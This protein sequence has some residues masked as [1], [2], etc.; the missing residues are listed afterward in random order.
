MTRPG[1]RNMKINPPKKMTRPAPETTRQSSIRSFR[2]AVRAL[3]GLKKRAT[4]SYHDDDDGDLMSLLS[5]DAIVLVLKSALL[6]DRSKTGL[7]YFNNVDVGS[8]CVLNLALCSKRF[9]TLVSKFCPE[10]Q[11]EAIARCCTRVLPR[12]AGDMLAFTKQMR[13]ELLSC[14]HIKML[15]AAHAAMTLHCGRD[16]CRNAR[17]A[18]NKDVKK[19]N[20]FSRPSSPTM[21]TCAPAEN[22]LLSISENCSLQSANDDGNVV[23]MYMRERLSKVAVHGEDRGRRFRDVIVRKHIAAVDQK[24]PLKTTFRTTDTLDIDSDVMSTP[25][26][27][28]TSPCGEYVAFIRAL[29][30]LDPDSYPFSAAFLWHHTWTAPVKI[31]PGYG[32]DINSS[33]LSAQSLWFRVDP[34]EGELLTVAWSS[35]FYHS[36]GHFVGSNARDLKN[37]QYMFSS[38]YT[39]P[40]QGEPIEI[41]ETTFAE[42]GSLLT[43]TPCKAGSFCVTLSKRREVMKGFRCV[44]MHDLSLSSSFAITSTYVDSGANGPIAASVSPSGDCVVVLAKTAKSVTANVCWQTAERN[45]T[46][47]ASVDVTPWMGLYGGNEAGLATDLVKASLELQFSPCG[48]FFAVVDRHPLFG[49]G[50]EGHGAVV[51]DTAMRG[52]T[53]KFRAFPLFSMEDQAPR[54]FQWT[55]QGLFLMPPGTDENSSIGSRGGSI[56]LFA[57]TN[58]SFA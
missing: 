44:Y 45:F 32:C 4:V 55:R 16:C 7:D 25:L 54:S 26:T 33:L 50:P 48:R 5:D 27:M 52:K 51:I 38:Y 42:S 11:I 3:D 34:L 2:N 40:T 36:S 35:D 17:R 39:D 31:E 49:A 14:D 1:K 41:S 47:V 37:S 28:A 12:D 18:F 20:V 6:P 22:Q 21:A 8:E 19:G 23:F 57:P 9:A 29:H 15:R 13:N 43:C 10:L 58:T 30:E 56:C 24:N 46:P 53:N